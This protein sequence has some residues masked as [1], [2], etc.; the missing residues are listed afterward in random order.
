MIGITG[1]TGSGK[2]LVAN[3]LAERYAHIGVS[4][5]DQDSYYRDRSHFSE[6]VRSQVNYDEADA[7][8][9]DLLFKQLQ[10]L[11]AGRPIEK[12]CYSFATHTRLARVECVEA[13]PLIVLDGLFALWDPRI[14]GL[15]D[16]KVY[17]EADADVRFIRRLRRDVLERGRTIDSVIDQ[18]LKTVRPM[19]QLY[20][21][22]TRAYA[23][24]VV[25]NTDRLDPA[26]SVVERAVRERRHSF[27][28]GDEEE[29]QA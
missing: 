10:Q 22:P 14:R 11:M 8:D 3:S 15:M 29:A 2:T 26:T 28:P 6:E 12:P 17:V 21:E 16:L 18:Y 7:I 24:I 4:L 9:H 13:K 19:Y 1:G 20:V 27:T 23:D 5:L 25:D